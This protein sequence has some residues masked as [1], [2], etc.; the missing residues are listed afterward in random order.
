M[1]TR[2]SGTVVSLSD[3]AAVIDVG[4][5]AYEI[6]LAPC[7]ADPLRRHP[8]A[9][10]TFEIYANLAIEGNSGRYTFFG[11]NSVIEREF[12][13]AL[14]SVA[15]IGPKSASRAFSKPM[16]AIARAIDEGD[17]A[18]LM[19]LPGIGRQKARDII[20]KLQGKV[21]R[22]LLIPGEEMQAPQA[23]DFAQ[24]ATSVLLQLG[25]R[26][27]EAEHLVGE[28]LEQEPGIADAE[29]LLGHIYRRRSPVL[30]R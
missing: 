25:Y 12:F 5:L 2:I 11:F 23:P 7:I 6:F 21:A 17:A 16:A 13:E 18:L 27:A 1:F 29:Q 4:G 9:R 15:S 24:E 28:I 10:A 8:P 19:T 22:F 3:Q 20:A 30:T 14:I 26:P